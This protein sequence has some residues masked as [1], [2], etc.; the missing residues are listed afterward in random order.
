MTD[1]KILTVIESST[2]RSI[3]TYKLNKFL[4]TI[5]LS[6]KYDSSN[7]S[8]HMDLIDKISNHLKK[9]RLPFDLWSCKYDYY[10]LFKFIKSKLELLKDSQLI[11]L[12]KFVMFT[13]NFYTYQNIYLTMPNKDEKDVL[14]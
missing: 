12:Y 4:C 14:P 6:P 11:E 2:D 7:F 9:M 13:I 5:M 10:I 8:K 1:I 3:I